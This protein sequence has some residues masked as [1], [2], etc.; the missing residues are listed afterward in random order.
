MLGINIIYQLQLDEIYLHKFCCHSYLIRIN[1]VVI[2]VNLFHFLRNSAQR[3]EDGNRAWEEK[4][5]CGRGTFD[6]LRLLP[7][8]TRRSS[9]VVKRWSNRI[10][11]RGTLQASHKGC[12]TEARHTSLMRVTKIYINTSFLLHECAKIVNQEEHALLGCD[13]AWQVQVQWRFVGMSYCHLH[14][15]RLRYKSTRHTLWPR[16]YRQCFPLKHQ[17]IS[18]DNRA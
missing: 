18:T 10:A 17:W 5:V 14:G 1:I 4:S 12:P 13:A 2:A 8:G 7:P 9:M 15:G 16:R 11:D 6:C 3:W